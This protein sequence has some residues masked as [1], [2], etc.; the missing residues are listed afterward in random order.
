MRQIIIASA[1]FLVLLLGTIGC[2]LIFDIVTAATAKS[3]VL[4]F[5]SAILLLAACAALLTAVTTRKGP[6]PL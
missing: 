5:G 1:I 6:P 3:V 4:K 2:L